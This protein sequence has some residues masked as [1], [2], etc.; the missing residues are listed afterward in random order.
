MCTINHN[1]SR[2]LANIVLLNL[3]IVASAGLLLR[4]FF[5]YPIPRFNF[6]YVLHAHSHFAFSGWGFIA[7]F[8]AFHDAFIPLQAK[9][10]KAYKRI[11]ILGLVAAYG[12]LFS[13]PFDGYAFVSISF[14]TLYILVSYWFGWRFYKDAKTIREHP[15]SMRFARTAIFF[16]VISS[17]GPFAMGPVMSAGKAGTPLYYNAIYF[18]L[19]FQYN[20]WFIF[21][22]FAL[23]FK[24]MEQKNIS[25]HPGKA[26]WFY[27]LMLWSSVLTFLLS[28]LWSKPGSIFYY[29]GGL[30][31]ML[32]VLAILPLWRSIRPCKS[33]LLIEIHPINKMTG[34]FITIFLVLKLLLQSFSAFPWVVQ[35][36]LTARSL[37]IGYLHLV[38]L[39]IFTL[40]LLAWF[41]QKG[42]LVINKL[43]YYGLLAFLAGIL[44]TE[45]FLFAQSMM[46]LNGSFIP[47]FNQW[48]FMLTILLPAGSG[49]LFLGNLC[50]TLF[51]R[52]TYALL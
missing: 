10:R 36:T 30:G 24:W 37:V 34:I 9:E 6:Q 4:F 22:I 49:L 12:M 44:L 21:G 28:I 32:Q 16:L 19:H 33:R 23:F 13:F 48:M 38:L 29:I 50:A 15:V 1:Q 26:L 3:F 11:F 39:G 5:I 51:N 17:I 14:S 25:F 8:I 20:G 45:L 27:R 7:L 18:Y 40:F 43:T 46:I 41:F 47:Q 35:W 31:G 2:T 52:R 42:F